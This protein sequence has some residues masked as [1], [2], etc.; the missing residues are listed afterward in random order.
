MPNGASREWAYPAAATIA[1]GS[2]PQQPLRGAADL[3]IHCARVRRTLRKSLLGNPA[4]NYGCHLVTIRLQHHGV[5]VTADTA[6]I[7]SNVIDM[8][9]C[10]TQEVDRAVVVRGHP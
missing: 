6:L 10:L 9:T 4:V 8:R 1:P 5:P 2:N 7:E 3:L